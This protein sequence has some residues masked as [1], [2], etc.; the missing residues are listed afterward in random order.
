MA[1]PVLMPHQGQSVESCIIN[2]WFKKKGDIIKEGDIL[3]S[4]ETDKA[5]FDFESKADGILIDV[6]YNEG[7]DVPVLSEVCV[8]G[9]EGEAYTGIKSSTDRNSRC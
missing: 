7:D 3:F 8:I 4:Y 6:F 2:R 5:T 1:L 9:N